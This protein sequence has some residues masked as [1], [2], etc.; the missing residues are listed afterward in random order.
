MVRFLLFLLFFSFGS[1][2]GFI[3][4]LSLF[5]FTT[6]LKEEDANRMVSIQSHEFVL[7]LVLVALVGHP[8]SGNK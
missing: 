2:F 3:I 6:T 4:F 7:E 8:N 5:V 1:F